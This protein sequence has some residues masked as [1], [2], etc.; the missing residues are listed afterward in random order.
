MKIEC[1]YVKTK[2]EFA[3]QHLGQIEG[4]ESMLETGSSGGSVLCNF[5]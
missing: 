1:A 5:S 3:E 4:F 2:A